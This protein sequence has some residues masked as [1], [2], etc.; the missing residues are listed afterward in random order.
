VLASIEQ[1]LSSTGLDLERYIGSL[2]VR[3]FLYRYDTLL[4]NTRE[5]SLQD[6]LAI[7]YT[8]LQLY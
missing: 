3:D 2:S 6:Y 4:F 1:A 8:R 7:L 5:L